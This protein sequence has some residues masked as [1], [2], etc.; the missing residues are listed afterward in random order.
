VG[1]LYNVYYTFIVACLEI[2]LEEMYYTFVFMFWWHA[3]A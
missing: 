1:T 2:N 3:K